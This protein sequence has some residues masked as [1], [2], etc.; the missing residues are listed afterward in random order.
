M[1]AS[2]GIAGRL[3]RS[4]RVIRQALRERRITGH[5]LEDVALIAVAWGVSMSIIYGLGWWFL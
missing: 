2:L 5:W 1:P 4:L 3:H